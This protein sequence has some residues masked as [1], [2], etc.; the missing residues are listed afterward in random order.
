[1][2]P[3][4][5]S[6]QMRLQRE[7]LLHCAGD[8]DF[9]ARVERGGVPNA[10]FIMAAGDPSRIP[11]A[12]RSLRQI[13]A[14]NGDG[15]RIRKLV[16]VNFGLTA[17]EI[18]D[19]GRSLGHPLHVEAAARHSA[20]HSFNEGV[21][22]AA[23]TDGPADFSIKLDDDSRMGQGSMRMLLEG[24]IRSRLVAAAPV[25]IRTRADLSDDTEFAALQRQHRMSGRSVRTPLLT[26]SGRLGLA[27]LLMGYATGRCDGDV[28]ATPN[29]NGMALA[30]PLVRDLLGSPANAVFPE[31]PGGSEGLRLLSV[32]S[33]SPYAGQ[34]GVVK[35]PVFDRVAD[36]A[37]QPLAFGRSDADLLFL[38][39]GAGLAPEGVQFA[40]WD[41]NGR[42][43]HGESPQGETLV[44]KD[45]ER[46]KW[47]AEEIPRWKDNGLA[48]A[49][50]RQELA[51]FPSF[52]ARIQEAAEILSR[53][54]LSFS[55]HEYGFLDPS[56]PHRQRSAA[57][58]VSG[59]AHMLGTFVR[60]LELGMPMR[61]FHTW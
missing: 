26:P 48:E 14:D 20:A 16:L 37:E 57:N 54:D 15:Y 28:P 13:V 12:R 45:I 18:G 32:I 60:S 40:G 50:T 19:I 33:Q 8:A 25:P 56:L 59:T 51:H 29:E 34:V 1:M 24:A 52:S 4:T 55:R 22:C 61:I 23:R 47:Y 46:F 36:G 2:L 3:L 21:R 7:H 41:A 11:T 10:D 58:L 39:A 6:E 5:T 38:L 43:F 27:R 9:F 35:A 30:A 31:A 53:A 42:L 49:F 44:L 17:A